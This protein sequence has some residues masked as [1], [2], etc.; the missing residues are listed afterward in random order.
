METS[1]CCFA[2]DSNENNYVRAVRA[3]PY[4]TNHYLNMNFKGSNYKKTNLSPFRCQIFIL[5]WTKQALRVFITTHHPLSSK[6]RLTTA[7]SAF[8]VQNISSYVFEITKNFDHMMKSL[9]VLESIEKFVTN[10][11]LY[12]CWFF[13]VLLR[14]ISS[15]H[16]TYNL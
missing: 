8:T 15:Q 5:F 14:T 7:L 12:I 16:Y 6:S 9:M 3:I 1:S 4:S 2:N 13:D 11:C 10:T